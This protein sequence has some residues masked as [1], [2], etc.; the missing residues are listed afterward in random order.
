MVGIITQLLLSVVLSGAHAAPS[1][2]ATPA[3][4]KL[5]CWISGG[6]VVLGMHYGHCKARGGARYDMTVG[7]LGAS[8]RIDGGYF[9]L[10]SIDGPF[11]DIEKISGQRYGLMALVG[12]ERVTGYKLVG[13]RGRVRG[14]MVGGGLGFA[15]DHVLIRLER[16]E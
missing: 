7:S 9:K 6:N 16:T 1:Q 2:F 14:W 3:P 8:L 11:Q 10:K 12:G 5:R 15:I 4:D 13:K